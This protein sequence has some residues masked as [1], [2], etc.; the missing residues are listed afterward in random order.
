MLCDQFVQTRIRLLALVDKPL[1]GE[2]K[3]LLNSV[4]FQVYETFISV[5]QSPN[6]LGTMAT[7]RVR[8]TPAFKNIP[9]VTIKVTTHGKLK[10]L[11]IVSE[12]V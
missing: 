12:G 6:Y 11:T 8:Y 7:V 10:I 4:D 9:T 3:C 1:D 2:V 5:L